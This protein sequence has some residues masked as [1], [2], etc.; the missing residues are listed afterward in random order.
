[1]TDYFFI[2]SAER[3]INMTDYFFIL[4]ADQCDPGTTGC[5]KVTAPSSAAA[6]RVMSREYGSFWYLHYTALHDAHACQ[7]DITNHIRY[8]LCDARVYIFEE[9]IRILRL[10]ERY[11]IPLH[12]LWM[13]DGEPSSNT[14]STP[15]VGDVDKYTFAKDVVNSELLW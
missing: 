3:I 10:S 14:S 11:T 5:I 4:S 1:M 2:L 13:Y 9:F 15:L 6:A 8:T 12:K 7:R